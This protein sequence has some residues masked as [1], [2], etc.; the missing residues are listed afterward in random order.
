M[1]RKGIERR[2]SAIPAGPW[3]LPAVGIWREEKRPE[4]IRG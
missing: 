3:S 2:I 1:A 4:G